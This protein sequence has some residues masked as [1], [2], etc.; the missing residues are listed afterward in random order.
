MLSLT[1]PNGCVLL[2]V[3][4]AMPHTHKGCIVVAASVLWFCHCYYY[5]LRL[6]LV[7][8]RTLWI[9]HVVKQLHTVATNK[10]E[11]VHKKASTCCEKVRKHGYWPVRGWQKHTKKVTMP[12]SESHASK[13]H[14]CTRHVWPKAIQ[15]MNDV[16][17]PPLGAQTYS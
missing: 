4:V 12:N 9:N 2:T 3:I 7:W 13:R 10:R 16:H 8:N 6:S 11:H 15:P 17:V 1:P 14:P 5:A